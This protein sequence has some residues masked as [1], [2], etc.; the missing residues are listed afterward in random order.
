MKAAQSGITPIRKIKVGRG[1]PGK[2]ADHTEV[3]WETTGK[4]DP[5]VE[6]AGY[7]ALILSWKLT[8]PFGR[9]DGITFEL[10]LLSGPYE[11][12]KSDSL[13]S[14]E[15][16]PDGY[17]ESE[18]AVLRAHFNTPKVRGVVPLG[19]GSKLFRAFKAAFGGRPPA[20]FNPDCLVGRRVSCVVMTTTHD[21]KDI[22]LHP[23]CWYSKVDT[24]VGPGSE[25]VREEPL[26]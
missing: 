22:P 6:P 19:P 14:T 15:P 24:F 12:G 16:P 18:G 23:S 17:D 21:S 25:D 4:K 7:D 2:P 10:K 26:F 1:R 3:V 5:L 20:V 13:Q 11:I 8:R 9:R